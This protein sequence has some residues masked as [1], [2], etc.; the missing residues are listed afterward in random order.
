MALLLKTVNFKVNLKIPGDNIAMFSTRDWKFQGGPS[1][2]GAAHTVC[3]PLVT[4]SKPNFSTNF[5]KFCSF[6]CNQI[7]WKSKWSLDLTL[8]RMGFLVDLY[9]RGEGGGWIS[10]TDFLRFYRPNIPPNQSNMVSN[11]TWHFYIP[12]ETLK[13]ILLLCFY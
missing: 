7:P 6:E 8:I 13:R 11:E 5:S 10:P 2:P 12:I 1:Y 3:Y 9:G 4:D